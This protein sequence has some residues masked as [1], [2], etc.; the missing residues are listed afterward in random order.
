MRTINRKPKSNLCSW[1]AYLE[2]WLLTL[3]V[4]SFGRSPSSATW[5]T[6]TIGFVSH[7]TKPKTTT[8]LQVKLIH[9]LVRQHQLN[10]PFPDGGKVLPEKGRWRS[11][12]TS[13]LRSFV[14]TQGIGSCKSPTE[15]FP[16]LGNLGEHCLYHTWPI[17]KLP[18]TGQRYTVKDPEEFPSDQEANHY[19]TR[20]KI[21][22]QSERSTCRHQEPIITWHMSMWQSYKFFYK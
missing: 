4:T 12:H 13:V 1:V 11:D 14:I 17:P 21:R 9:Y 16:S 7:L 22:S 6:P 8:K 15:E 20:V 19:S 5:G 3:S 10:T 18:S 2:V